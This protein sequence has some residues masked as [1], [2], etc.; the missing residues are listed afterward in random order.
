[1]QQICVFCGSS[2]GTGLHYRKAAGDVGKLLAMKG[3]GLVYGGSNVGLMKIIA[4]TV[5]QNNGRV[6]G[7]M[8][9]HLISR[10]IA[11]TGITEMFE[12][13]TMAQRKEMMISISDAFI[14]LPGGYGTLDELSEVLTFN[15]LRITDK[16]LGLLNTGGYF[17]A[18][19]RF[20]DHGVNE[21]FIRREHRDNLI[22]AEDTENLLDLL[23]QWQ[24][25]PTGKWIEEILRE[26]Q[27]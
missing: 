1:M 4:D 10:E 18:L 22:V 23:A 15:Q 2:M 8:P 21:G 14:A 5:L 11:H 20:F 27:S 17:D 25:V 6:T 19:L 13:D 24:P 12:V 16:P 3:I 9:H 7:V 26:S